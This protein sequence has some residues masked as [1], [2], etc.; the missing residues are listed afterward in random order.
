MAQQR[1]ASSLLVTLT[2]RQGPG[3]LPPDDWIRTSA[4]GRTIMLRRTSKRVERVVDKMSLSAVVRLSRSFCDDARCNG[5]EQL[6]RNSV[7]FR[8]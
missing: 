7:I 3:A 6:E 8:V 2:T 5:K 4:A 1:K